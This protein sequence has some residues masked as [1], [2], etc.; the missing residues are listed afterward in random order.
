MMESHQPVPGPLRHLFQT[1]ESGLEVIKEAEDIQISPEKP[2]E[3]PLKMSSKNL[4]FPSM[5]SKPQKNLKVSHK[6][7][8]N[9]KVSKLR[10]HSSSKDSLKSKISRPKPTSKF[11]LKTPGAPS[12]SQE[13]PDH[14]PIPQKTQKIPKALQH[15]HKSSSSNSKTL[16]LSKENQ[17]LSKPSALDKIKSD[18]PKSAN[19]RDF[20]KS[21]SALKKP[22]DNSK[23]KFGVK[24]TEKVSKPTEKPVKTKEEITKKEEPKEEEEQPQQETQKKVFKRKVV[25]EKEKERKRKMMNERKLLLKKKISAIKIQKYWK[26][27]QRR[28]RVKLEHLKY[29]SAI[30]TIQRFAKR[31]RG[32]I[33]ARKEIMEH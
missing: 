6:P 24:K 11:G 22:S 19:K 10:P 9:P 5:S 1:P 3:P 2:R 32:V 12:A 15:L 31:M 17:R 28:R 14:K 27:R 21:N 13:S 16:G 30:R 29:M 33:K 23:P 26:A 20:K 7:S 4:K 18:L 25:D 8:S